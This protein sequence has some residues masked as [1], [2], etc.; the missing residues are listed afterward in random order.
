MQDTGIGIAA[1]ELPRLFERFY[2]VTGAKGRSFEGSGIGLSLVQELVLLHGGT[3]GVSSFEGEGSCFKVLIPTG[4][5]HL[6]PEQT[7]S[8]QTLSSTTTG[9]SAYVEEVLGWLPQAGEGDTGTG[10]K[11]FSSHSPLPL[12]LSVSPPSARILLVDDNADMRTYLKRLLEERWQVETAANGAI[13]LTQIQQNPP[14]LVLT[15]IMMPEMDGLQLL[16]ALRSDPQNQTIPVILLSA[17]A[18]EKA[19]IEGLETGADDYLIK[20]F[21]AR[22][23]MARVETHLQ[24][25]LLRQERSANRFKTEFLLS[26]THELQSPLTLIQPA[27]ECHQVHAPRGTSRHS[28]RIR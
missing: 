20:P 3:I 13:A 1:A 25:A 17:R 15:D 11:D 24:L 12:R 6:H 14:D 10:N 2:Q 5:A 22:E 23:L 28:T 8:P 18:G 4:F 7:G 21:S 27:G 16:Q 19:T 26:V 9:A